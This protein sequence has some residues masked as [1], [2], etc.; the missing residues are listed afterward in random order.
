MIILNFRVWCALHLRCHVV[1]DVTHR[2]IVN[3]LRTL[4]HITHFDSFFGLTDFR[5][6]YWDA[7]FEIAF[8]AFW[9]GVSVEL[10]WAGTDVCCFDFGFLV[11][12]KWVAAIALL[13]ELT[14]MKCFS[15]RRVKLARLGFNPLTTDTS[16]LLETIK[17]NLFNSFASF[18]RNFV[19]ED[20][21]SLESI[22]NDWV[23]ARKR[24]RE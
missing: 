8:F 16:V 12:V 17:G 5:L 15:R 2:D 19:S 7:W 22:D 9:L 21:N 14:L 23:L 11:F 6:F 1:L 18:Y 13:V 20:F 3:E 10:D 4:V 24:T